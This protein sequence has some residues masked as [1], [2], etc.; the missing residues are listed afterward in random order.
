MFLGNFEIYNINK[1]SAK[2]N[3]EKPQKQ[4]KKIHNNQF[5]ICPEGRETNN[6]Y[7]KL[8]NIIKYN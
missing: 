2:N 7:T 8:Y 5:N 6:L 1:T 3:N 4:L